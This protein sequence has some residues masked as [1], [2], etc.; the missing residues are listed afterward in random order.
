[1]FLITRRVQ[2][3]PQTFLWDVQAPDVARAARPGHFV[4]ARIDERGERI[5]LTVA[6]FNVERGT[7]T[8]V[9]QAVGKTTHE[10]MTLR[11]G[12]TILDFI[13]PLG[14][15]SHIQ[16]LDG[17][18]VLVGGG[19]GVA[20]IYPQLREYKQ[21][22]NRTISIIGFRTR[23]LV[24]WEEQFRDYSDELIVATD[25][26][27]YGRKGFVTH[28]L[29]DILGR[30]KDVR[31][32]VAIGPIPMM[33]A[34]SETTR[35]FAVPTV[36]SLNSIM[37]D[38]T[39]MCGSCRVTV[40]GKMKFACVDG[41]DFDG[42]LVNF[43]ELSLRQKRFEREEKAAM[44]RFRSESAKLA[45]L[46]VDAGSNGM[47]H[48]TCELP[49]PVT[50]TPGPRVPKNIRTI[51]PERAPMPHQPPEVRAHNFQEVALGLDLAGALHEAE[52]CLRCKKPRCVPGCPV[53]IDIPAFIAAIQERDI[54]RS[55]QILKS[56]NALPAV[57]GRVCPQESQ[58]EATCVV[59]AKFKPVAIGRLER[60]VA[61]AARGRGWDENTQAEVAE[62]KRA[63]I[64]GSG[65]SGLACAGELARHG[66]KVTIFEALHVAGGV[67][68]YGIPEFRL[69]DVI[70]DAEIDNLKK[71]GVEIR[72]D[73][74]I[75]KLFTI[76]QLLTEM[77]Y[78][79][80]FVG[81]GAGSPKFAE[82]PGEAFNG[83]FSAN[84]FL[85]RVNLMRG[86][87]QPL[88]DTPVGM[89][90][91]VA[92][93]GAGNTAMD[94]CRVALRMGAESVT[95]VYRR[96]RRESPARAEELEHAI[97]EGIQF[98]WLTAPVEILGNSAGW[99][100]GMR[101]QRM[102]LGEPDAS[103]RR[104]PVAVAGSDFLLDVDTVIY[105]LGTTANPIIAQ[106][107]PGLKNN[108]W[109]YIEIDERTG[110]TSIPGL[111]AGGDIVTGAATVI[112]A[113]GA[114]KRAAQGMLEFMGIL[115][116][117]APKELAPAGRV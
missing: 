50:T 26:G 101:C 83:V 109:G 41:A 115:S 70:I 73:T 57:C 10:M 18:V 78:N 75:G 80:A 95:C 58:C 102:E 38:G 69:P 51:P 32:V 27:S 53:G 52:R 113:M 33:K 108:K 89:G 91:R 82:I 97:E 28:V 79:A 71:M 17:T 61:D 39:G 94:A 84:E 4:M 106:T 24:F 44:E 11:Q 92:V 63:A 103:G 5:P 9:I 15:P 96:S 31:E 19:L 1:M 62:P 111:F 117:D 8:V 100:T 13:G 65:P 30:E 16:K 3:G 112:L 42:H 90:K 88:Y 23:D 14:L 81:T 40:G 72:L 43:E 36:V 87:R 85:T 56:T 46:T 35:P 114:G 7:V 74:I 2:F 86:Y 55:Y 22:G 49:V 20:P 34:C 66:V 6:D 60:F 54:K 68:K 107:T 47:L 59:G 105:A 67:L 93:V 21:R 48:P 98:Q 45:S 76:P 12:D 25:D 77:G 29:A 116:P 104:R 64:I 37:V 99:V 110:M